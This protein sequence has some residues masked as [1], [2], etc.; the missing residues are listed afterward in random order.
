[1]VLELGSPLS[2][3][4]HFQCMHLSIE[5]FLK[6]LKLQNYYGVGRYQAYT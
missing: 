4:G 1:M 3:S 6:G 5:S 2:E